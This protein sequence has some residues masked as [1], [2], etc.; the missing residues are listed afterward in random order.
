MATMFLTCS[1]V[2]VA[3]LP[4]VLIIEAKYEEI[5][6]EIKQRN[7]HPPNNSERQVQG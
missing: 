5:P 4:V 6:K 2:Y 1:V 3:C 7:T